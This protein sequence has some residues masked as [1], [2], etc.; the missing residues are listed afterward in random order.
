MIE[1]P[2]FGKLQGHF[3]EFAAK[4]CSTNQEHHDYVV[5]NGGRVLWL[6]KHIR[7]TALDKENSLVFTQ[8]GQCLQTLLA[9]LS[10]T[11]DLIFFSFDVDSID[12]QFCPGVSAPSVVGGLSESEAL[13]MCY[14]AGLFP[15]VSMVDFSEYNPAVDIFRT[16]RLLSNMFYQFCKGLSQRKI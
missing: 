11:S 15:K 8:A 4:G 3:V 12:S 14:L 9:D 1:D 16:G 5:A 10:Q 13:E 6:E 7:R 2:N